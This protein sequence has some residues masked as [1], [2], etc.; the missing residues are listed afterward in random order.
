MINAICK[1]YVLF[2][3]QLLMLQSATACLWHILP[4]VIHEY[5]YPQVHFRQALIH[6]D[7][8]KLKRIHEQ[9]QPASSSP[10]PTPFSDQDSHNIQ[11]WLKACRRGH[12]T[13]IDYALNEMQFPSDP[14]I[15]QDYCLRW[16][17]RNGH[18]ALVRVLLRDRRVHPGR[19]DQSAIRWAT[20]NHHWDV[21]RELA[22][23]PDRVDLNFDDGQLWTTIRLHRNKLRRRLLVVQ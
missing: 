16:A 3:W 1:Y 10:Y 5:V 14:S 4:S 2:I 21:V 20:F 22:K 18:V 6:N 9:S 17:S 8:H 15:L 13:V 19:A 7:I 12:A 23:Y 11:A